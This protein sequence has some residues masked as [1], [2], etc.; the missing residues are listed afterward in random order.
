MAS[1]I[2]KTC[3]DDFAEDYNLVKYCEKDREFD[4]KLNDKAAKAKLVKGAKRIPFDVVTNTVSTN[5]VFSLGAW[6]KIVMPFVLF[7]GETK[8]GHKNSKVKD[9]DVTIVPTITTTTSEAREDFTAE[10]R[11]CYFCDEVI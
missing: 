5:L 8:E 3:I 6:Y 2:Q 1:A 10:K 4:Y 9:T 11:G 7:L